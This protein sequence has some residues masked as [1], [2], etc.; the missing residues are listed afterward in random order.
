MDI[1]GIGRLVIIWE[2]YTETVQARLAEGFT[3]ASN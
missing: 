3:W 1:G 2:P